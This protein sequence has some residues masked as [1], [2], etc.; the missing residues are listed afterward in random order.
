[1]LTFRSRNK[2]GLCF[3]RLKISKRLG[4]NC[5]TAAALN[6]PRVR[7]KHADVVKWGRSTLGERT[8]CDTEHRRRTRRVEQL[9]TRINDYGNVVH[10]QRIAKHRN[11]CQRIG[12]NGA[13]PPKPRV[14]ELH[15]ERGWR[16]AELA[17]RLEV[18]HQTVNS[19]ETDKY[20]PSLPLAFKI[21]GLLSQSIESIFEDR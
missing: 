14:K 3:S 9:K 4:F 1:M 7:R 19:I 11:L 15:S 16:Q 5:H 8:I 18:S 13:G 6:R 2:Q 17:E 21:A 10:W 20:D 12:T